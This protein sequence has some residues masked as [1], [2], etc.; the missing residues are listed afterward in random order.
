MTARSFRGGRTRCCCCAPREN[1][2]RAAGIESR[3]PCSRHNLR[4]GDWPQPW[5]HGN[6]PRRGGIRHAP[7]GGRRGL[8]A[9]RAITKPFAMYSATAASLLSRVSSFNVALFCGL[10]HSQSRR[11]TCIRTVRPFR[12]GRHAWRGRHSDPVSCPCARS[13]IDVIFPTPILSGYAAEAP[14]WNRS[15][16]VP[17]DLRPTLDQLQASIR[18]RPQALIGVYAGPRTRPTCSTTSWPQRARLEA[19]TSA[20][21]WRTTN[22]YTATSPTRWAKRAVR[23]SEPKSATMTFAHMLYRRSTASPK[24]YRLAAQANSRCG[25]GRLCGSITLPAKARYLAK[26]GAGLP[27]WHCRPFDAEAQARGFGHG[28]G[29]LC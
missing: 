25:L 10:V 7:C 13:S 11:G 4:L 22:T 18:P 12:S 23:S 8:T 2:G 19:F 20:S 3:K 16:C 5:L 9:P 15:A 26:E 24:R 27:R 28:A 17:R 21:N 29:V 14:R 6:W 1:A